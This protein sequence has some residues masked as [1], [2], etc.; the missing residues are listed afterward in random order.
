MKKIFNIL[1]LL[2]FTISLNAQEEPISECP[3]KPTKFVPDHVTVTF[4]PNISIDI[5]ADDD[6]D[7]VPNCQE[8]NGDTD[9]DGI[10][11]YLD[12]DSDN[13]GVMDG[14]DECPLTAG[15]IQHLGCPAPMQDRFVYWVH[16]W[17]GNDSSW[18]MVGNEVGGLTN[19]V[20]SG[21]FKLISQYLDY[22]PSQTSMTVAAADAKSEIERISVNRENMEKDFIIAH[23][24][25]GIVIREMGQL[26]DP[27]GE[28]R[29]NGVINFGSCHGG[30][31]L[32]NTYANNPSLVSNFVR[33]A[34]KNLGAGPVEEEAED[35]LPDW[36][37]ILMRNFELVHGVQDWLCGYA[38]ELAI[39]LIE[40]TVL[41]GIEADLTT[42]YISSLGEIPT[43]HKAIFY[44]VE[45]GAN[46][47]SLTPRF[48]GSF[49]EGTPNNYPLYGA[50]VSDELGIEIYNNI[51]NWYESKL[52]YWTEISSIG[53]IDGL[54]V[55]FITGAPGIRDAYQ[56]G[57]D[58]LPTIND[59]WLQIIEANTV[60]EVVPTGNCSCI[61]E[62]FENGEEVFDYCFGPCSTLECENCEPMPEYTT[63]SYAKPNDGFILAESVLSAPGINYPPIEMPGSNHMQMKND[64]NMADAVNAIFV[65]G[66]GGDYFKTETR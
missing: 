29:F 32:A 13:D 47:G 45:D 11:N 49:G 41:E 26:L 66:L 18:E 52:E 2:I 62:S 7:G 19:G 8:G 37:S 4:D 35:F 63:L 23:S 42:S 43:D 28:P 64:S 46:G 20:P 9:G 14:Q 24:Q 22:N 17:R 50:D 16:G 55:N 58:F 59:R 44:G 39:P 6:G 30:A 21:N 57:V 25:G 61:F 48:L 65:Q 60:Y 51:F 31:G 10:P 36:I 53:G 38:S 33:D 54:V 34:C 27:N 40:G 3:T 1:C 56:K 15:E 5:T 12:P